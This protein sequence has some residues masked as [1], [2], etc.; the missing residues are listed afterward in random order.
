L[1]Q[2]G[3]NFV[4]GVQDAAIGI[5]NTPALLANSVAGGIDYATGNTDAHNQIRIPYIP[6]PDWSR[7]LIVHEG[8]TPGGWDGVRGWSKFAGGEGVMTLLTG[9]SRAASA[10]DDAGNCANWFAKFVNGGCFVSGTPVLLTGMPL[11]SLSSP[12]CGTKRKIGLPK[13]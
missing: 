1:Q 4:N 6:S 2:G 8:G 11:D 3:V 13:R 10:V 12:N 5:A 9:M 7:D